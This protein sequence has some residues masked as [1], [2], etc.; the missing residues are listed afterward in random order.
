MKRKGGY[1]NG[2]SGKM[3]RQVGSYSGTQ[4]TLLQ[5]KI[6]NEIR[7]NTRRTV[8][9]KAY[10]LNQVA[11]V[12]T[13]NGT[14]Y[15]LTSGMARGTAPNERVGSEVHIKGLL[16]RLALHPPFPLVNYYT[17]RI[18]VIRWNASGTPAGSNILQIT[19]SSQAP[20]S[21]LVRDASHKFQVLHDELHV[22]GDYMNDAI[23]STKFYLKNIG[24]CIWDDANGPQKGQLFM[25]CISDGV[26]DIPNVRFISRVKYTDS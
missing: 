21:P 2:P 24:N 14:V 26:I 3:S 22:I 1:L 11:D 20:Y 5:A 19:G 17:C 23:Y 16:V 18:V 9:M 25:L 10:D 7:K 4:D 8:E 12:F 6:R 13:Y 15:S